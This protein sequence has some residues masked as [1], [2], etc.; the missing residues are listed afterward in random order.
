MRLVSYEDGSRPR[1]GILRGD[2][3]HAVEGEPRTVDA[4]LAEGALG[5]LREGDAL[6]DVSLLPPV[7]RPGKIVCIG[8]NYS[9]HAA[10]TGATVPPEPTG[11]TTVP[12]SGSSPARTWSAISSAVST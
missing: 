7:G 12:G 3:V 4:L 2:R 10:E 1:A 6:D 8:L 11:T 9:D 5:D